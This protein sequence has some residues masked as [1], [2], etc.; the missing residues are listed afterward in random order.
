MS[1]EQLASAVNTLDGNLGGSWNILSGMSGLHRPDLGIARLNNAS[2]A[3]SLRDIGA[4]G[5]AVVRVRRDTGG[6]AGDDDE[7]DFTALEVSNGTLEA[8]VGAGND[9]FVR[10][11]YN[12]ISGGLDA[13]NVNAN[14]QPQLVNNGTIFSDGIDFSN[15]LLFADTTGDFFPVSQPITVFMVSK[16]DSTQP[17]TGYFSDSNS[18]A[19]LIFYANTASSAILTG[20]GATTQISKGSIN[21]N[22]AYYTL[23]A[24]GAN[25]EIRENGT[26]VATGDISTQGLPNGLCVGGIQ[27]TFNL[28]GHINE[29][30]LFDSDATSLTTQFESSMASYYGI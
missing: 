26:S 13:F 28:Q 2:L 25:S 20:D 29:L 17:A 1:S 10:T 24:N 19:S 11:W 16:I 30:T 6:G 21:F 4:K 18:F 14:N 22:Q 8:F 5:G 27:G 12:Q 23:L 7:Q 3:Y 9:G 15:G